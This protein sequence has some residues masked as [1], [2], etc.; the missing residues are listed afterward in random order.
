MREYQSNSHKSR[1]AAT[2]A[3]AER[4]AKKVVTGNVKLKKNDGRKIASMFISE[5]IRSVKTYVIE[6]VIVPMIKNGI[7]EAG[8]T[9]IEMIFLGEDRR[10]RRRSGN[11]SDRVSYR[12]Y[13]DDRNSGTSHRVSSS[14]S[15]FEYRD[16]IFDNRGD[17]ERV[18]L[19]LKGIRDDYGIVKVGDMYDLMGE[20]APHTAFDYGWTDLSRAEIRRCREGYEI[21][22]PKAMAID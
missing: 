16:P 5:D 2:E 9:F 21:I 6:E 17:A 8:K 13:Y 20:V 15:Q 3:A 22:L 10:D 19:E 11:L 14:S 7:V 12:R 1:E 18:L 4:R